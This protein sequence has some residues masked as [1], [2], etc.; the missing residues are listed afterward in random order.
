MDLLTKDRLDSLEQGIGNAA[1]LGGPFTED[2]KTLLALRAWYERHRAVVEA[3]NKVD[4]VLYHEHKSK[5]GK[6][7]GEGGCYSTY[8]PCGEMHAHTMTCGGYPQWCRRRESE[9]E[10][11]A[12]HEALKG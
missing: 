1:E 6:P 2:F 11:N 7:Y 12:L 9:P 10:I 4:R 8:E 5:D 3:A